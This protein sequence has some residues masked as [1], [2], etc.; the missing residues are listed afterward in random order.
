MN[1]KLNP[2]APL[3]LPIV[4]PELQKLENEPAAKLIPTK[5]KPFHFHIP[6]ISKT[7]QKKVS[8]EGK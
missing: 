8:L 5:G 1:A 3:D 2:K 4:K 7:P 6:I